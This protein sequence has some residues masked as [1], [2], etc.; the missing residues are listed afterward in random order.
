MRGWYVGGYTEC[1]QIF[2]LIAPL[3]RFTFLGF[4]SPHLIATHSA[5]F[6]RHA[7]GY[8]LPRSAASLQ[9]TS[10]TDGR[11][12]NRRP[13]SSDDSSSKRSLNIHNFPD[14]RANTELG[15]EYYSDR[16]ICS[17]AEAELCLLRVRFP[18]AEWTYDEH[19]GGALPEGTTIGRS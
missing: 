2:L 11:Q 13:V 16:R 12:R 4:W 6:I 15:R 14:G 8:S 5:F 1:S 18:Q 10:D 17:A 7:N 3:G 9:P 19:C